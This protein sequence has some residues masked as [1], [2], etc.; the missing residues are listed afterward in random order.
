M[1]K[2]YRLRVDERIVGFKR[3]VSKTM[4]FY[5][6]N[7]FWWNGQPIGHKQIDEFTGMTDKNNTRIYE[8][9]IVRFELTKEDGKE[10][11]VV[12]WNAQDKCFGIKRINN[13]GFVPFE[14]DSVRLFQ[15]KDLEVYSYLFINPEVMNRLG[16]ED[17]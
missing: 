14:V 2:K 13:T 5:S 9:D 10:E 12:L 11:G 1:E 15:S 17:V 7:E 16:L 3:Q 6:K 4:V 8:W